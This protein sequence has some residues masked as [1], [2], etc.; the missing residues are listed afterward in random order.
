VLSRNTTKLLNE[1]CDRSDEV[2]SD[3]GANYIYKFGRNLAHY[4]QEEH[5]ANKN[6]GKEL[7]DEQLI[8]LRTFLDHAHGR[9]SNTTPSSE[10]IVKSTELMKMLQSDIDYDVIYI[11]DFDADDYSTDLKIVMIKEN[12]Y[13]SLELMWQM[14]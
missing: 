7:I 6:N 10:S 11:I 14:D 4:L 5:G 9:L 13:F 8:Q 3:G 12:N 2:F 1:F